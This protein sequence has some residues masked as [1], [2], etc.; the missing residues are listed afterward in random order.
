[1][2]LPDNLCFVDLETTGTATNYHRIIEIGIVKVANGQIVREYKQLVNPQTY[3]DPFITSMTGITEEVLVHAPTFAQI[4]DEVF[5]LL[6]NAV[7]VAHNVGFD[8][9]FLRSEFKRYD[10]S[11][12]ANHFCTV[13]LSRILFPNWERHN[14]DAVINHFNIP[15]TN[16]HR[17]YD[18][19]KVLYEFWKKAQQTIDEETF[20]QAVLR[21]LKEPTPQQESIC[22]AC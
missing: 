3:I 22:F 4:K 20:Q 14:L 13:R 11:F 12:I 2:N 6:D 18:D 16:R 5:E 10:I 1:M 21:T 15:C 17:A 9:G 8:Y 7:F 19:A